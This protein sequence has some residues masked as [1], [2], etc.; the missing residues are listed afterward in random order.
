MYIKKDGNYFRLHK[1]Q[2]TSEKQKKGKYF[3]KE[4]KKKIY[5]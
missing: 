4:T 5:K 3:H 1:R 2:L